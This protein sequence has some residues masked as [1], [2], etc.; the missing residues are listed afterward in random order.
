MDAKKREKAA[1]VTVV[2]PNLNGKRFLKD[3]LDSLFAQS[4]RDFGVVLVDNASSDGSVGLVESSYPEVE[5]IRNETNLGFARAANQGIAEASGDY[6]VLLNNDTVLER[7]WLA[8]LVRAADSSSEEFMFFASKILRMEDGKIIES[9]GDSL[10]FTGMP[11]P[12]NYEELDDGR[13]EEPF[14]VF[15][16]C[17]AGALYKRKLFD[18]VGLF[19]EDFFAYHEDTDL[20]FR[21]QLM[22]YKGLFVPSARMYH[23]VG[24]TSSRIDKFERYYGT[25]NFAFLIAKNMPASLIAR[26]AHKLAFVQIV[27][28]LRA[29][30]GLSFGPLLRAHASTLK[31]V[32]NLL[33]K[34]REIQKRRVV[35]TSYL[36]NAT[37]LKKPFL[38]T[39]VKKLRR[40]GHSWFV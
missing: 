19:D 33:Q 10:G 2:I 39:F 8:N 22:G 6:I 24:G 18:E 28:L 38:R 14:P 12:L 23:H 26:N 36:L 15:S 25:R 27:F 34:R 31:N 40:R 17:A 16:A 9:T 3:C 11:Y 21:A 7:D 29:I 35:A 30:K 4:F 1:K 13:F 32:P 5:V 37:D 20:C